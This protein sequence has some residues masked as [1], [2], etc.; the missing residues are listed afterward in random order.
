MRNFH[1]CSSPIAH[2]PD[3]AHKSDIEMG[4]LRV[5][6]HEILSTQ[7]VLNPYPSR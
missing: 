5:E 6:A 4:A 1:D 7:I 3:P 2:F